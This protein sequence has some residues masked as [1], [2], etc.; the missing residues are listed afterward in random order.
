VLV[1]NTVMRTVEDRAALARAILGFAQSIRERR[2][3]E[4]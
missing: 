3:Q 2:L 1:A 4:A